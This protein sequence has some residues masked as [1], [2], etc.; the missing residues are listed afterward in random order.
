MIVKI[1]MTILS[2]VVVLAPLIQ[3]LNQYNWN[4]STLITPSYSP[5]KV[6]FSTMFTSVRIE[7]RV[8]Y[9]TLKI[10]NR[11]EVRVVLEDLNATAYVDEIVIAPITLTDKVSLE[12]GEAKAAILKLILNDKAIN[13]LIPY[14]IKK[15]RVNLGVKGTVFIRVLGSRASI[16][17]T[18]SFSI[19]RS[20][21]ELTI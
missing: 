3:A 13:T 18:S 15:D 8:L 6:D 7:G 10:E 21:L 4:I 17:F 11:G 19:S 16:P 9:I 5:P 1:V 20:D 12:P 2:A 14:L